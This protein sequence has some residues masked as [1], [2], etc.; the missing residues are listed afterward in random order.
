MSFLFG[1]SDEPLI[2]QATSESIPYGTTDIGKNFEIADKI[3]SNALVPKKALQQLERRLQNKNPN[4]QLLTLELIDVCIKNSGIIFIQHVCSAEFLETIEQLLIT[5]TPTVVKEKILFFIQ[6]WNLLFSN[7]EELY[8]MKSFYNS[9]KQKNYSF[10]QT[11]TT[12]NKIMIETVLAP[13]WSDA[14]SCM[15][16][17]IQFSTFNRK[18]HCRNCGQVFCQDCSGKTCDLPALGIT[19]QVR[20][21]ETCFG[22]LKATKPL[23]NH[24]PQMNNPNP[25]PIQSAKEDEEFERAIQESLKLSKQKSNVTKKTSFQTQHDHSDDDEDLRKA[26]QE[27]LATTTLKDNTTTNITKLELENIQ[28]FCELIESNSSIDLLTSMYS[29]INGTQRKLVGEIETL[30]ERYKEL[31]EFNQMCTEALAAYDV[32]MQQRFGYRGAYQASVP[33]QY[34]SSVPQQYQSSVP[35][36][37]QSSVPQQHPNQFPSQHPATPRQAGAPQFQPTPVSD[38]YQPEHYQFNPAQQQSEQHPSAQY[39]SHQ[40]EQYQAKPPA[41]HQQQYQ[42]EQYQA[43][44][45][46][47]HQLNLVP[48]QYP[49]QYPPAPSTP[50]QYQASSTPQ[51]YPNSPPSQYQS[52]PQYQPTPHYQPQ[53]QEP[54]HYPTEAQSQSTQKTQSGLY[55][56]EQGIHPNQGNQSAAYA[57]NPNQQVS[58][59]AVYSP[60]LNQQGGQIGAYNQNPN[61]QGAQIGAYNQNPN[62]QGAQIGAYNPHQGGQIGAY[63]QIP[64][65]YQQQ[66]Q[67]VNQPTQ[68]NQPQGQTQQQNNP[69]GQN[70]QSQ[71]GKVQDEPLIQL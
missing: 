13:P 39:P 61:Q 21:C 7:N 67:R 37:Y 10:P 69:Q 70:S 18:H 66:P 40:L 23:Q 22:K 20:V 6:E 30:A 31:Y 50:S 52:T 2:D 24:Q 65:Q 14:E 53:A 25:N 5:N 28:K 33:Q 62:Q 29:V 57:S 58:Q 60:T 19:D 71:Q 16:C 15:R 4:V 64:D 9:L 11:N 48:A 42:P 3:K 17:R 8:Q 1:S 41:Q 12:S 44:P 68:G 45:Q 51:Q 43:N 38:Q 49:Q 27:S 56:L 55:S 63:N 47:Q 46:H 35:Q 26:I 36:Q 59:G 54:H 34:Q 32:L